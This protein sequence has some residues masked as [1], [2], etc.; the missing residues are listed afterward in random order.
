MLHLDSRAVAIGETGPVPVGEVSK[1]TRV[2]CMS[3]GKPRWVEVRASAF[4]ESVGS[5]GVRVFTDAGDVLIGT[6]TSLVTSNGL[7]TGQDLVELRDPRTIG[8]ME[9]SWPLLETAATPNEPPTKEGAALI[10]ERLSSLSLLDGSNGPLF[11]VG[12]HPKRLLGLFEQAVIRRRCLVEP[13][14]AGWTWLAPQDQGSRS[15]M[16]APNSETIAD[17]ALALWQLPKEGRY[18]LPLD[19]VEGRSF[20]LAVLYCCGV[21]VRTDYR[22]RYSPHYV[23]LELE[24]TSRP[25]AEIQAVAAASAALLTEVTLSERG[26]Y[27]VVSGLLCGQ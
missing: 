16:V 27:M 26:C 25:H 3:Q 5:T 7:R 21:H 4:R 1:G 10:Y 19:H 13:G 18:R 15:E 22:P 24:A 20:T 9:G 14:M 2:L 11:R 8:R 17:C 23:D 12:S 6:G